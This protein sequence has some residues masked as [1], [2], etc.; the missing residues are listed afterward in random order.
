MRKF[1]FLLLLLISPSHAVSGQQP[2]ELVLT[3]TVVGVSCMTD[4]SSGQDVFSY[5]VQF[6]LQLRN[7]SDETLIV[8]R[9][10]RFM[11]QKKVEFLK[12]SESNGGFG[13]ETAQTLP[14][15][16]PLA[17]LDYNPFPDYV[18]GLEKADEPYE[19]GFAII[20]AGGYFEFRDTVSVD[21]GYKPN[22]K[23]LESTRKLAAE[24]YKTK[25]GCGQPTSEFPALRVE[26][27]LSLKKH[28]ADTDFLRSIQ[29]RWQKF[30]NLYLNGNGDFL[31]RSQPI[32]NRTSSAN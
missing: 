32:V 12:H 30:G 9:P 5:E 21:T 11:G 29:R 16:N 6:Y 19:N 28:H 2:D 15:V 1:V 14:W 20:E 8:F 10:D 25:F 24:Y 27:L 13:K 23:A 3:G 17:H 26:Y 31:V 22:K 7:N 4:T 18:R